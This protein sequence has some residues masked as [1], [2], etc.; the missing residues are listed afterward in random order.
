MCGQ[1]LDL[2]AAAPEDEGVTALET[3]DPKS[4]ARVVNQELVDLF[5]GRVI[6][7]LFANK[8]S[9]SIASR[10]LEHGFWNQPVVQNHIRLWQQ[11]QRAQCEQ[12]GVAGT[13]ADE[14]TLTESTAAGRGR[15]RQIESM[16]LTP[17][18]IVS[19]RL[20]SRKNTG[21]HVAADDSLPERAPSTGAQ[22]ALDL[23]APLAHE[24]G[25]RS[26]FGR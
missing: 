7:G 2:L 17:K 14:I 25:E 8:H 10:A 1:H 13:S 26:Q 20:I 19:L 21:T 15:A 16:Q 11:L 6:A 24:S 12:V 9:L 3:S 5:L 18:C 4:Q 23:S 22:R